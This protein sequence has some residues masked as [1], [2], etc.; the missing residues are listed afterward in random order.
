MDKNT[1]RTREGQGGVRMADNSI[2]VTVH[3]KTEIDE[4]D[5]LAC[6]RVVEMY[7]NDTGKDVF[8]ERGSD[9][10]VRLRFGDGFGG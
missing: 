7:L 10:T 5:A 2:D 6:L 8:G 9:G 4:K 3:I 1:T